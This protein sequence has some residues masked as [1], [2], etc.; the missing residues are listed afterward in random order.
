MALGRGLGAILD[1]VGQAYDTEM[2]TSS[3]DAEVIREIDVDEISPV[4]PSTILYGAI[5]AN[6]S[7]VKFKR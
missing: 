1:E 6:H 7:A 5:F 2:G 4:L 3:Y